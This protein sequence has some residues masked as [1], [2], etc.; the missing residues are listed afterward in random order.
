M[1]GHAFQCLVTDDELRA[2][3]TAIHEALCPGGRF[4][5]ET[6]HPQAR[7]WEEWSQSNPDDVVD[8]VDDAGRVL[9]IWHDV[10]SVVGDV[11]TFH[12]TTAEPDGTVLRIDRASLRFLDVAALN[13]FLTEAGFDIEALYGDW[14]RGPITDD[15]R[16][17]ITIARCR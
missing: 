3:L 15:S 4:A 7:A 8:L 17:I 12:G 11:V 1:T 5:F 2:S 14:H 6:R 10:G 9:R 13:L 16:E